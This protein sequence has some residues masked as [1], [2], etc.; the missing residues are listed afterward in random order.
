MKASMLAGLAAAIALGG[1][2]E[3]A[4]YN[5]HLATDNAPDYT[6]LESFVQSATGAWQTPQ[7]KAIAVW[8]WGRRSRRQTSC[9]G[10]DG[11]LVW[12]PILHYN[13]YGA[14]NCGVISSLNIASWLQLGYRGRYIQL[15]DHT[16][17]EV[18]WDDGKTWHLFDSSMSI[19][20]FNHAG[21]VAGC[22]EIKS[23]DACDLSGG[24]SEPGHF[25]FYHYA[26]ACGSHPGPGGWRCASDQPVGYNRT[27]LAGASS[28]TD[29]FSVDR[30]CQVARW[31]HRYTLNLR[32]YESYTR[33]WTPLDREKDKGGAGL[34][35]MACFRPLTS[36]TPDP[37][38]SHGL[39]NIRGSGR[40]LLKPDLAAR[41]CRSVFYDDSGAALRAEDG[42]GPNLHPSAAADDAWVVFK[43]YAANVMTA[44]RIE[45]EGLRTDAA[46]VLQLAVSRDA[47]LHWTTVWQAEGTGRQ[48][49]SRTLGDE[50][51]GVTQCLVKVQMRAAKDKQ[52]V[53][54]DSL[55]VTTLTQVNRRTLPLLT[56][57]ANQV[58]LRADAQVE[59][60]EL[61][62]PLHGGA[63]RSTAAEEDNVY[64][65]PQPDG[66]YKATLGAG[67]NGR[68]CS[69][70][71]R[72]TVPTDITAVTYGV[73]ST[74]RSSQSSVSLRHSW[75][76]SQ[77]QPFHLK[78]TGEFPMDE[79]VLRTF[80][81]AEVPPAARQA[82]FRGV[83]S[84]KSGAA[85]YNMPGIQDLLIRVNH[86]P[87]DAAFQP[88]EVTY[89]WTEHRESGDVE[90]SH[91]ELVRALPHRY[92]INVAG[93]RDPTMNWVR[94]NLQGYGPDGRIQR[95]GYADGAD[96]GPGW[97]R[98]QVAYRWGKPAALGK[99]YT[100][101]RASSS[102]SGNPDTGGRELTNGIVI[103]PTE[104]TRSKAVQEATAFWESGEPVAFVVDLEKAVP[105]AGV[106]ASTH[107]PNARYCHPASIEVSL[108]DD[109]RSWRPAGTVRHDDL[110]RPPGDYEA[111]EHD[112]SPGYA[113]L[114]AGG[115]LAYSYPLVFGKPLAARYVRFLCT[116]LEGRGMGLSEL[117][118]FDRADVRA[119][120]GEIALPDA[121]AA[122]RP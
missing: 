27:L 18:S 55:Q 35:D 23:A 101:S 104:E 60:A 114:P 84:C 63:Y 12:D 5:L 41:D 1:V 7:D 109:G 31:G 79:Q 29:G 52:H 105:V 45:A 65:D 16:V 81:G 76:G 38:S 64:S 62:P 94:V 43:V 61:W 72:M 83:F 33:Y 53:G 82:C 6:D 118:V 50:V 25:Y 108:S 69:V 14:M 90:R 57:G 89:A 24:R 32:P 111:W 51:A 28:Y 8:R 70:T 39:Y 40:W 66:M 93:R 68:D 75:D 99:P 107:Q 98:P 21:A 110:W 85:T 122:P 88:I 13:S 120:P 103:A 113:S 3:A 73:I 2:A 44:M 112:D 91:T 78:N 4:V 56:L 87:R 10:E 46:D 22:E 106:R 42:S 19:Y 102:E 34:K 20:C 15:G 11:R 49:A 74:N 36:K 37:D 26:P 92:T 116:P 80:A 47:G 77:F 86:R 48:T 17:S 54:L 119:W 58:L 97:E 71:W 100:A 121:D 95:Y 67:V 117:A 115:R 9:A 30:Y 96:V 59:T